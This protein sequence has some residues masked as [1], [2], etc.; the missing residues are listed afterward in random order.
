MVAH[1]CNP[2][3]LGGRDPDVDPVKVVIKIHSYLVDISEKPRDLVL[4]RRFEGHLLVELKHEDCLNPGGCS[5]PRLQHC[6]QAWVTEQDSVSKNKKKKKK[7]KKG[8]GT[9]A[10]TCNSSTLGGRGGQ[11]TRSKDR[12]HP[13]QHGETLF[14]LKVQKLAGRAGF[15]DKGASPGFPYLARSQETPDKA[16]YICNPSGSWMEAWSRETPAFETTPLGDPH[17]GRP[18][19][20]DRLRSGVRD[21]SD[22]NG[23]TPSLLNIEKGGLVQWL[24]PVIPA[25]WEAKAGGSRGQEFETNLAN[26]MGFH[27]DGQA[28]LELLT[29]GQ[30]Q[31]L[32][33][34][35]PA[36]WE[37]KAGG[38]QGQ[39]IDT[40]LANMFC[41]V[42]QA[43]VQWGDPGSLQ[44]LPPGFKQFSCLSLPTIW[45]AEAGGSPAVRSSRPKILTNMMGFHHDGQAGLEL[46][47]SPDPPTLASQ[48]ARITGMSHRARP[49]Y[50]LGAFSPN[51]VSLCC[52]SWSSGTILAHCDLCLS[53]SN[54]SPASASRVAGIT[55]ACC[56]TQLIFVFLV[57]TGFHHICQAG[58]ELLTSSDQYTHLSLP[59]CW[60][61]RHESPWLA[62]IYNLYCLNQV[63]LALSLRLECNGAIS[64][65]CN[66]CLLGSS[67]S[68]ALA[69][70]VA[71]TIGTRHHIRLI[72]RWGFTTL[73]RLV[74]NLTSSDLEGAL[75]SQNAGITGMSHQL[76]IPSICLI[77]QLR[78][79]QTISS[80]V[81]TKITD[82]RLQL[83]SSTTKESLEFECCY[84]SRSAAQAGMITAYLS[85]DLQGS[86]QSSHFSPHNPAAGT[87]GTCHCGWLI[88]VFFEMRFCYVTQAGLELLGS[89]EPLAS[90]SQMLNGHKPLHPAQQTR[91]LRN[92]TLPGAQHFG[93]LRP[94]DHLRSGVRDQ[95][96]QHGKIL[97]LI[98]LQK[99]SQAR[100]GLTLLPRLKSSAVIKSHCELKFPGFGDLPTLASRDQ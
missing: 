27:H 36:L 63:S 48:S 39:E 52:P 89:S 34:V 76:S 13:G 38:S 44:P 1:A 11:I 24:M 7:R 31:W 49:R 66:L 37:A 65:H 90:P 35:V 79:R 57:E 86:K 58:L 40:I 47:T 98:K 29:S 15:W 81:K 60:D 91:T 54:N 32:T 83:L 6:T 51:R 42:T 20:A 78:A 100:Q 67:N 73:A 77:L 22:Q 41:S 8:P 93:R 94:V 85:L 82:L 59:K 14:L 23:E 96:G 50:F 61:Y 95:P 80:P 28:G 68:P 71:G 25:L 10:H 18:R 69:S 21:Q 4:G 62:P 17:I 55:G 5:E 75:A 92:G 53:G 74:S 56:Q 45:K 12:D 97:S 43:R 9:V 84:G 72:F 26:M 3:T 88:F 2:S 87:T 70:S 30:V 33:P 99:L 19:R 46:L 16:L 64:A